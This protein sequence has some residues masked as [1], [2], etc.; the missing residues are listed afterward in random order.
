MLF[1]SLNSLEPINVRVTL[2]GNTNKHIFEKVDEH[3]KSSRLGLTRTFR[4][5]VIIRDCHGHTLQLSTG[6]SGLNR[7]L[8]INSNRVRG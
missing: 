2:N 7:R 1:T 8:A 6:L 4:V 5:V 3:I